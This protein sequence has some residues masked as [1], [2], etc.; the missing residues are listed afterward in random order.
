MP[1]QF[2][3][4]SGGQSGSNGNGVG[5]YLDQIS[6]YEA[7]QLYYDIGYGWL[8][9]G[10]AGL[11]TPTDTAGYYGYLPYHSFH[12][13]KLNGFYSFPFGTTLGLVYEFDSGHAWQKR[14]LVALYGDYFAFPEGRGSRFMKPVHYIDFRVGHKVDIG[15]SMGA[16]VTLDLFNLPDLEAPITAYEN[17]NESFGAT[18]FRQAPR[19]VRLGAKFTY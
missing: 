5:V 15:S 14:G 2:E 1:G 7:K 17:D 18:F 4:S 8:V 11:G 13:I 19:S 12:A 9:D 6:D 16:E 3:L 10:L